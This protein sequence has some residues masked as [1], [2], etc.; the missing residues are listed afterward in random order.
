MNFSYDIDTKNKVLLD[1]YV[2]DETLELDYD[3]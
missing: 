1:V 3:L 2:N